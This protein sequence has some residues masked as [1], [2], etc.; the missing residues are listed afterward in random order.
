MR[1]GEGDGG[2]GQGDAVALVHEEGQIGERGVGWEG[3][4]VARA[5]G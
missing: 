4:L 1:R 5:V 3:K 2:G